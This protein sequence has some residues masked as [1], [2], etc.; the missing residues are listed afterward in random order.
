[1]FMLV[2]INQKTN[3]VQCYLW[4]ASEQRGIKCKYLCK[5]FWSRVYRHIFTV[6]D[7]IFNTVCVNNLSLDSFQLP[8]QR[9]LSTNINTISHF[10]QSKRRTENECLY[11]ATRYVIIQGFQFTQS[12]TIRRDTENVSNATSDDGTSIK[13]VLYLP[14]HV[15]TKVTKLY[16]TNITFFVVKK[17]QPTILYAKFLKMVLQKLLRNYTRYKKKHATLAKTVLSKSNMKELKNLYYRQTK[18]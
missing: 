1:M 12:Q 16:I 15:C 5:F 18:T 7:C 3:H 13:Q 14:L 6:N 17:K 8:S 11:S 9:H 4:T 10:H 2:N